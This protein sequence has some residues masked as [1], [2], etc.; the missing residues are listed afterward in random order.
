VILL[1]NLLTGL[2]FAQ[3]TKNVIVEG[4]LEVVAGTQLGLGGIRFADSTTQLT[5]AGGWHGSFTRIKILPNDFLSTD[6]D[7]NLDM[8]T[9]G[10]YI[11]ETGTAFPVANIAVPTGFM[12]T[13]LMIYGSDSGNSVDVYANEIGDGTT[14]T[15]LGSGN[16]NTEINITDTASTMTNYISVYVNWGSSDRIYGGYVT[17]V[18]Q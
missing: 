16:V 15:N 8:D 12:A 7:D 13:A 1:V 18:E 5:A 17:I 11:M 14:A 9:Q 6:P 10:R 2:A 3:L 4:S